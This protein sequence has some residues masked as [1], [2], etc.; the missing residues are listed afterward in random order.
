MMENYGEQVNITIGL[1]VNY[2]IFKTEII[3]LAI[4][5]V[6]AVFFAKYF[7]QNL[8]NMILIFILMGRILEY[9]NE[10]RWTNIHLND[11]GSINMQHYSS[12]SHNCLLK[13][14]LSALHLH[15]ISKAFVQF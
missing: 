2:V 14:Q 6:Q 5:N 13:Y 3:F 7:V 12:W 9:R 11:I 10:Y 8:K 15:I 1:N 4:Q